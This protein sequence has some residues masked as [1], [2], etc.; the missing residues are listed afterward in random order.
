MTEQKTL[1][2]LDNFPVNNASDEQE[3]RGGVQRARRRRPEGPPT[4]AIKEGTE[5]ALVT[6]QQ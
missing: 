2:S 3:G 1:V 6:L 4:T 5:K